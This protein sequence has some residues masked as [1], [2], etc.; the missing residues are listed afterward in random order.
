MNKND[1]SGSKVERDHDQRK[2][3]Y[4]HHIT[5][6]GRVVEKIENDNSSD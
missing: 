6:G 4:G 3:S 2:Y 5:H 1:P